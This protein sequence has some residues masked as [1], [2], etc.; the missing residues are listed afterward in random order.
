MLKPYI[1]K[2][3]GQAIDRARADGVHSVQQIRRT[4]RRRGMWFVTCEVPA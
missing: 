1:A 4:V 3:I 2:T